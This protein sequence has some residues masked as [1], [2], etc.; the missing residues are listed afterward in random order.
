MNAQSIALALRGRRNGRGWLVCCPCPHHGNG[1]GDRNPSLSI[2]DGEGGRLLA[3]C[4]AGCSFEEILDALRIRGLVANDCSY[5]PQPSPRLYT[6]PPEPDPIALEIWERAK[7]IE[8]TPAEQYLQRRGILLTPPVLGYVRGFMVAAVHQPYSGITAI[9]KTV[10]TADFTR[11]DRR[12]MGPLGSGAVRLGAAQEIMGLADGTETALSAMMLTGMSV[13][14]CLGSKRMHTVELPPFVRH[15]HIFA[16]NDR[17]GS[18]AAERTSR[19][20]RDL[21]R[22]VTVRTPPAEFEDYNAFIVAD[23]DAWAG[24]Q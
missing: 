20:H 24:D 7:P 17:P 8:D 6:P 11:G 10:I 19:V 23:A 18:D 16:D 9:Q 12:T 14:A 5:R 13:W 22:T 4:F 21:G 2:T 15:I 3:R 1:R